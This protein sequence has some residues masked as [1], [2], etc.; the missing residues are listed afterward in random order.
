MMKAI[1]FTPRPH[2]KRIKIFIPYHAFDWRKKLKQL[3]SSFYHPE[4]KLWSVVNT[5]ANLQRLKDIVDQ[6]FDI[7]D[8]QPAKRMPYQQLSDQNRDRLAALEQQLILKGY[9][10]HTVRNYRSAFVPFLH[11][12]GSRELKTVTKA[13]IEGYLFKLIS[14]YHISE[15]KQNTVINAI[16]FYYE[17]VGQPREYYD[18][19]RP[20]QGRSLPN[21]LSA[22]EV[23]ALIHAPT[24]LKHRTILTTIYS[25]GLRLSEVLNV[26][27]EDVHPDEGYIFIRGKGKRERKTVLS[28][29]L[30]DILD[31]YV[32]QYRPSYWLFEGQYGDQYSGSS[33]SQLFRRA[34]KKAGVNPWATPHTLRH[35][36]ATH[37]LQ[38][39]VN[40]RYVQS[41][42]GHGS[43][44][45][46]EIYT[47][48]MDINNKTIQS[49]LDVIRKNRNLET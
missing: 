44:K 5:A 16:K 29:M 36:F 22:E 42:L 12:F 32:K 3:D 2:A 13:E 25:G 27:I 17:K 31:R 24:N 45:T 35:S 48:V 43:P 20:K 49:P 6:Q 8:H 9:S 26:R 10:Q 30:V 23:W 11:F 19:Q 7:K 47:H 15:T 34:V 40:L 4:Q 46:T 41:M 33:I 21:V 28:K 39:G 14:K 38:Q 37:L 1:I 18:L